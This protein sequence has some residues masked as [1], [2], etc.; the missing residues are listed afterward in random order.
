MRDYQKNNTKD[1]FAFINETNLG[2]QLSRERTELKKAQN[3]LKRKLKHLKNQY[4]FISD[5]FYPSDNK[6]HEQAVCLLFQKIGFKSVW[7]GKDTNRE[8]VLIKE[9]D[10]VCV[11]ECRSISKQITLR[12]DELA[13]LLKRKYNN[14]NIGYSYLAVVNFDKA[15]PVS[16]RSNEM[17][18]HPTNLKNIKLFTDS[19]FSLISTVSL[20]NLFEQH[21]KGFL[22]KE[23]I[24]KKLQQHGV[25]TA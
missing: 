9:E 12:D 25:I 1:L 18:T 2:A 21:Q 16:Q 8:D 11:I 7:T 6:E 10:W 3:R 13:Q 22:T 19:E 4:W 24:K 20:F 23:D 17:H 5:L 15:T 14:P